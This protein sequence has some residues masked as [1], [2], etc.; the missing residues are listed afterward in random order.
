MRRTVLAA[1][2]AACAL[3]VTG[4]VVPAASA[5]PGDPLHSWADRPE[6][7]HRNVSVAASGRAFDGRYS[8]QFFQR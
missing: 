8:L 3:I 2:V 6:D 7:A 5:Y 1:G 4:L